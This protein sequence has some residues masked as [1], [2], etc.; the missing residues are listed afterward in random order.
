MSEA[1][2]DRPPNRL[3][4]IGATAAWAMTPLTSGAAVAYAV[5]QSI[6]HRD[7]VV[8][9]VLAVVALLLL[10]AAGVELSVAAHPR[11]G[12]LDRG[13]AVLVVA[14]AVA[15]AVVSSLSMWGRNRMVQDDWGQIAIALIVFGLVWLRPPWEIILFGFAGG[16]V[17]GTLAGEQPGLRISTTP[18]VYGVV[19]ATPVL[20]LAAAA[21]TSGFVVI[22][23]SADWTASSERG[24]RALEPEFRLLEQDALRRG[25]LEELRRATL[26]LLASIAERGMI[27]PDDVATAAA[28]AAHLRGQALA[29]LRTTWVDRLLADAH[30][31]PDAVH[32]PE[33]LLPLLRA[34]ERAAFGACLLELL[35]RGAIDAAD[36]RLVVLPEP[37]VDAGRARLELSTSITADWRLACRTAR[38]FVSVLRSFSPD[39]AITRK[40]SMMTMRFGFATA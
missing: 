16:L 4:P 15:A 29:E 35:R 13:G 31:Q 27:A 17:V 26:P 6:L 34:P 10:V 37:G 28:V 21:A 40:G 39:A 8:S 30:L 38:P 14:T 9:P 20:V 5:V 23:F 2:F 24:M 7:Q 22:R 11:V 1:T 3:D 32:D 19:A 36:V 18:Y 33:R 25:Q 12:R